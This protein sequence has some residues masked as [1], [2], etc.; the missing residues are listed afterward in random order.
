MPLTPGYGETPL[1]HDELSALTTEAV[2]ILDKPITRAAVYDLEQ[3]LEARAS[4]ELMPAAIDGSL[5][6]DELLGDH[7]VRHLH[8]RLYGDIWGWAGRWRRTEVN[9]GV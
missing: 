4:G 1:P 8:A 9:I 7:F 5:S 2:E 6:L 3:G